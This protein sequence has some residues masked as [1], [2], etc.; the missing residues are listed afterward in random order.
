VWRDVLGD[1]AEV[2]RL[3]RQ[4]YADAGLKQF[5]RV[6]VQLEHVEPN[7]AQRSRRRL[8]HRNAFR[9]AGSEQKS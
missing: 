5:P 8:W 7:D 3:V 9:W 2:P 1:S 4:P 6:Q